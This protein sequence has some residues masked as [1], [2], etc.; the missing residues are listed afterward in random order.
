MLGRLGLGPALLPAALLHGQGMGWIVV[1]GRLAI[2]A[3]F[4]I[5]RASIFSDFSE[6][7]E[8]SKKK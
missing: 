2:F 5:Y 4:I 6:F 7:Q 3:I 1:L 8:F